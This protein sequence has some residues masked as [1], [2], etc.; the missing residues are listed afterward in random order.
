MITETL[1]SVE[2]EQV[3]MFRIG[4]NKTQVTLTLPTHL[5]V[6]TEY[7]QCFPGGD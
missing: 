7:F 6:R 5:I 1:P 4:K 3:S 2:G